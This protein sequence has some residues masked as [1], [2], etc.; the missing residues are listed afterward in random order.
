[1]EKIEMTAPKPSVG[2]DEG[3][4][5]NQA[6]SSIADGEEDYKEILRKMKKELRYADGGTIIAEINLHAMRI[7]K[8][9]LRREIASG[10]IHRL[11]FD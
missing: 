4:S 3:Q 9:Q 11:Q 1:M 7:I 10:E 5:L 2:A 6:E 8:A